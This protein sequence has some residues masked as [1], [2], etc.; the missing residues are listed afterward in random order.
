MKKGFE[1]EN[2]N[3]LKLGDLKGGE[4][5]TKTT[6]KNARKQT[7]EP[8]GKKPKDPKR[9]Q[10]AKKAWETIRAKAKG[11]QTTNKLSQNP[12]N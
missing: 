2:F 10:A 3:L 1:G 9:V 5:M 6:K 4:N 8:N 12:P 7:K 11:K